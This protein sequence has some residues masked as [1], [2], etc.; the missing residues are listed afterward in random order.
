MLILDLSYGLNYYYLNF[1]FKN[2]GIKRD[3]DAYK[4]A[5][6]EFSAYFLNIY[7]NYP[8]NTLCKILAD[9]KKP[10]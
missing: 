10:L 3:V 4:K 5:T 8:K 6:F 7:G 1:L 9:L 2:Q